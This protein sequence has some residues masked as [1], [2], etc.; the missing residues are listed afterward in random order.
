MMCAEA[1]C[2][3]DV[4]SVVEPVVSGVGSNSHPDPIKSLNICYFFKI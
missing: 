2:R 1:Q 3:G 4:G